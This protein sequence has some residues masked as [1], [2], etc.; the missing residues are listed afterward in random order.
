MSASTDLHKW[1]TELEGF[2]ERSDE[3]E[4]SKARKDPDDMARRISRQSIIALLIAAGL[5][6]INRRRLGSPLP[7]GREAKAE[8]S[9]SS[10]PMRTAMDHISPDSLRASVQYLAS[11]ELQGRAT[12][13]V[14]LELRRRIHRRAIQEG[15]T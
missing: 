9:N 11:D 8:G 2:D 5:T 6:A 4:R 14:G 3:V 15:G 10:K 7:G 13:S 1:V 12:P